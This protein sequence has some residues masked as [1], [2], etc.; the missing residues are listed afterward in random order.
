MKKITSLLLALLMVFM[1]SMATAESQ[2]VERGAEVTLKVSLTAASGYTAKIGINVN[3]APVT[4]KEAKGGPVND[5][6]PPKAVNGF[7]VPFNLDYLT[8]N[9]DGSIA[10]EGT[11]TA[12][13]PLE[14]GVIGTVIFT[15]DTNAPAGEYT[16]SAYVE[17]GTCTV[18]GSVTFTVEEGTA[19]LP[20]DV[21]DD[22]IVDMRDAMLLYR[23]LAEWEVSINESNANVTGDT[24]VDMRD[25]MLLYRYL[26]EWDVE[27]K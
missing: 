17:E 24:V 13:K 8:L 1:V 21:N 2:V 5:V 6:Y 7:F 15:V 11:P 16:I 19:R 4:F 26:A 23:Y 12:P 27:L 3:G 9:P 10:S 18:E 22:K 25:A 14:T 20:G